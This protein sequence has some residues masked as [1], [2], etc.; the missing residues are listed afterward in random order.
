L[1]VAYKYTNIII[2]GILS[3]SQTLSSTTRYESANLSN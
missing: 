3:P 1:S 2:A